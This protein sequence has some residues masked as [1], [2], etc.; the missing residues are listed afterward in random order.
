M[1]DTHCHLNFSAFKKNLDQTITEAHEAGISHI[2]IPG[3]DLKSSEKAIEIAQK[4]DN[5]YAA[6]GIHP[7]HVYE[8]IN[9]DSSDKILSRLNSSLTLLEQLVS[10]NFT[11]SSSKLRA[12]GEV[13][14]DRHPYKMTKYKDYKIDEKFIDLQKKLLISQ[15][16]L[17]IKY[18]KSLILHNR[19]AKKDLFEVLREVW[20]DKL[21]G[22]TVLHCCEQDDELL[23]WA[24]THNVFIGVD[25]DITYKK[26]KQEFVK[27]IPLEKLVLET[28][29]PLLLPEPLRT[30]KRYPNGPKNIKLI[31]EFI[32]NILNLTIEQFNNATM[33]NSLSLFQLPK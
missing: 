31:A 29:S 1:F 6:V 13:G 8:F 22:R 18:D 11:N 27:K 9:E 2:M 17:A 30:E 14:L 25:G 19:E 10:K 16:K 33:T 23:E 3:T 20:D 28:D 12:I 4:N 32:A 7:H 24:K 15:I 26:D 21:R 5:I